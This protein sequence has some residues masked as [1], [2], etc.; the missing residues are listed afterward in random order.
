[1]KP[2]AA[3]LLLLA[4]VSIAGTAVAQESKPELVTSFAVAARDAIRKPLGGV[5]V[6]EVLSSGPRRGPQDSLITHSVAIDIVIKSRRDER[7]RY[8]QCTT[9][10]ED[11]SRAEPGKPFL[12]SGRKYVVVVELQGLPTRID[13][14]R[15]AMDW[16]EAQKQGVYSD[17]IRDVAGHAVYGGD[18]RLKG[19]LAGDVDISGVRSARADGSIDPMAF[20]VDA[21]VIASVLRAGKTVCVALN[22]GRRLETNTEMWEIVEVLGGAQVDSPATLAYCNQKSDLDAQAR[23]VAWPYAPRRLTT[24]SL[25]LIIADV[26]GTQITRIESRLPLIGKN[27]WAV[28]R[29]REWVR[30]ASTDS[31][32]ISRPSAPK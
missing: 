9:L 11:T 12:R 28:Q 7:G 18:I 27:D 4:K 22:R 17:L 1:M 6:V 24:D 26:N 31:R 23:L 16:D 21:S 19:H 20:N 3:L 5:L 2:V 25:H 8:F 15:G 10:G 14:V 29:V 30:G 13:V 32:A